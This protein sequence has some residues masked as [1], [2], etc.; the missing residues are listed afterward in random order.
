MT[1]LTAVRNNLHTL[2]DKIDDA[3]FLGRFYEALS[4]S[5]KK[6][7]K[8][9]KSLSD[10]EREEVLK[11]FAE[12]ERRENLISHTAVRKKHQKWLSK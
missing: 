11:A 12:S 3:K 2:I 10:E 9:W 6:N 5:T 1:K 8:L 7:T 4:H